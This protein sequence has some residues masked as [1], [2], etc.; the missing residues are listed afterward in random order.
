MA[1][2]QQQPPPQQQQTSKGNH[3]NELPLLLD[4]VRVVLV[5]PKTPANIGS[6]LRVAENFEASDCT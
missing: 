4:G 1:L 6:V 3:R 5:S 2:L